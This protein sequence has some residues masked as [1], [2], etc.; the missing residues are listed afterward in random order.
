MAGITVAGH[1]AAVREKCGQGEFPEFVVTKA[2]SRII[3]GTPAEIQ[4]CAVQQPLDKGNRLY[5]ARGRTVRRHGQAKGGIT[6]RGND[7]NGI[8]GIYGLEQGFIE[9][10][11]GIKPFR[12]IKGVFIGRDALRVADGN[13]R[14]LRRIQNQVAEERVIIGLVCRPFQIRRILR[15]HI[16]Q[17]QRTGPIL[18]DQGGR[19]H[20]TSDKGVLGLLHIRCKG[21]YG[22]FYVRCGKI[23][24]S[25]GSFIVHGTPVQGRQ[26]LFCFCSGI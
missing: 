5:L 6:R 21:T 20:A 3:Q 16:E 11:L 22:R 25:E 26:C 10:G 9:G 18:A 12:K 17:V 7:R 23:A 2:A 1:M 19:G 15:M 13:G 24:A 14:Q 4:C 8:S